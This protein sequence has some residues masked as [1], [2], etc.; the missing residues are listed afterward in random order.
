MS[1][2]IFC[3]IVA[4]KAPAS[5]V[6]EDDVII[7]FMDLFPINPGHTL[8]VPKQ[9]F[10]RVT[11]V[12]DATAARMMAVARDIAAA[13]YRSP[14][15]AEGVNLTLADGA[16]AGQEVP[17]A[18]LHVIPRFR[19]DGFRCTRAGGLRQASRAQ[20]EEKATLLRKAME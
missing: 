17:H 7:A 1:A 13:I 20:L 2:C 4:K 10:A 3:D 15:R 18:H 19:G 12:D 8:V 9:H 16:A 5:I 11:D 6:Y 14:I